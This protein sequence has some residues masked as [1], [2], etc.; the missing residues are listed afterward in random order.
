MANVMTSRNRALVSYV[1]PGAVAIPVGIVQAV[2]P[3]VVWLQYAGIAA[4]VVSIAISL[5]A[6]FQRTEPGDELTRAAQGK[7]AESAMLWAL[8]CV[9]C[10]IA[11]TL[12]VPGVSAMGA[13]LV[14]YGVLSLAYGVAFARGLGDESA[15]LDD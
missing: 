8:V 13:C 11:A 14:V 1:V 3:A 15:Y 9:A 7:A 4:L 2:F 10:I 12:V 5:W 6:L